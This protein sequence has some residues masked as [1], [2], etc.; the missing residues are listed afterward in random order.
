VF[1]LHSVKTTD[2]FA[3]ACLSPEI[4]AHPGVHL[5]TLNSPALQRRGDVT[6]F[7]PPSYASITSLPLLVLLHGVYGSHWNWWMLGDAPATANQMLQA[8]AVKS[9]MEPMAIAMPS[10]CLWGEGSGYVRH[11][12]E[13]AEGWIMDDVPRC[14]QKFLPQLQID[15]IFLAG[16]SM[17]GYGALRLGMK[18][19]S[20]VAGISA[21]SSVTEI[22]QL[23]QFVREPLHEYLNAGER[24]AEILHWARKHRSLLPPIRFDCG[25]MDPLLDGNRRLSQVLEK[26][27]IPHT[28]EEHPGGHDW[29][30]WQM[31]LSRTLRFFSEIL[32][33]G[34]TE[35]HTDT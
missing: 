17:G 11:G 35:K 8:G 18:H 23:Q 27:R 28:Y 30:Y 26:E 5:L 31:H 25:T 21:H 7:L 4:P 20:R 6:V 3:N 19:A 32:R 29:S 13:D 24:D 9:S 15:R 33:Q 1:E 34:S 22:A 2:L 10:D 14:L 12:N 16:Q